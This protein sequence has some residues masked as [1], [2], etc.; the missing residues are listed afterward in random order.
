MLCV[1][2]RSLR[3]DFFL[4]NG[5]HCLQKFGTPGPDGPRAP[6]CGPTAG[7]RGTPLWPVQPTWALVPPPT[8]G[9]SLGV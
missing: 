9:D 7:L 3:W 1:T 6:F 8:W 5:L 4:E 2:Y